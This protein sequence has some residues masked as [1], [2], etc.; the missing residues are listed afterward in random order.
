[1]SDKRL[2]PDEWAA[3]RN[4][5]EADPTLSFGELAKRL[6]VGKPTVFRRAQREGW[7]R[8]ANLVDLAKKA[9]ARA[10]KMA[11]EQRETATVAV[12]RG[13]G[14][15]GNDNDNANVAPP[16]NDD[17][18]QAPPAK[19]PKPPHDPA[20]EQEAAVNQDRQAAA[21]GKGGD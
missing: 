20:P 9:H 13:N 12:D 18:P 4:A 21:P 17:P 2:S 5:W 15:D 16:Q 6:G 14:N 1:M 10:D 7:E 8:P 3:A 11:A 19:P